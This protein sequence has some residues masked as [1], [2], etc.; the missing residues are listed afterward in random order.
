M[1]RAGTLPARAALDGRA[2]LTLLEIV[3]ASA[4][5][6]LLLLGVFSSMAYAMRTDALQREREAAARHALQAMEDRV[7]VVSTEVAFDN[8]L[9]LPANDP[10]LYFHVSHSREGQTYN[11][12]AARVS[13]IAGPNGEVGQLSVSGDVNGDGAVNAGDQGFYDGKS[14][15]IVVQARVRWHDSSDVDQEVIMSSMKVRP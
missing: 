5:L 9:A 1:T 11:F 2:G 7:M 3:I 6:A 4:V 15:L 8:L 14:H 12:S 10:S 13:P